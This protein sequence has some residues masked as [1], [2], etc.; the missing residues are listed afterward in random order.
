MYY[1]PEVKTAETGG[2]SMDYFVFGEG[3][4][5]FVMLPGL[6]LKKTTASAQSVAGAYREF[7]KDF[8]VYVFERKN[9]I[10]AGYSIEKMAEDTAAVMNYLGIKDAYIFGVSQG[11]MIAQCMA[12]NHPELVKK[13]ILASTAAQENE[14]SKAT[15]AKWICSALKGDTRALVGSFLDYLYSD[16]FL[17]KYKAMILNLYDGTTSDELVRFCILAAACAGFDL[18]PLLRKIKCPVL[19]IGSKQDK[20]FSADDFRFLCEK[21]GGEIYLYKDFG[22]AVY[23]E[24]PDFKEHIMKFFGD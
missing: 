16:E 18:S 5:P 14:N 8:T 1:R 10:E 6:S 21:T 2:I 3:K 9:D 17:D 22:H 19:V 7:G 12:A 15:F 20:I 24:A 23:D 11:G 13:L 4:K